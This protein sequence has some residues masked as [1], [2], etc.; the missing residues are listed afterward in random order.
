MEVIL[1]VV[2]SFF[3]GC[4]LSLAI[5]NE[6]YDFGAPFYTLIAFVPFY[7]LF[8]KK[9]K[10]YKQAFFAGFIQTITT[11]LFSSYWLAYFKDFAAITLGASAFGTG[12][13]GGFTALFL[14]LPFSSS[15]NK[16]ELFHKTLHPRF[17]DVCAF[18]IV[19]FSAI[20]TLYEWIKSSG[21]LG[22]PWGT[23]SSAMYKWPILMQISSVAGTYGITF[24]ILLINSLFAQTF[25]FIFEKNSKKNEKDSLLI[26][27]KFVA[28]LLLCSLVYGIYQYAKP[29]NPHKI[30]TTVMVQQ[31]SNPWNEETDEKS[32]LI[33]QKLTKQR[34]DELSKINKKADLVVWSEGC[35]KYPFPNSIHYY[36]KYPFENP[37]C[38]FIAKTNVPFL[39]GGSFIK[40]Q[41]DDKKI[42]NAALL[43]DKD[44]NLRGEYGKNHLVPFAES[45][46]F[47][48][49]PKIKSFMKKV[50]GISAGWSPGDQYVFF[51]IP[52]KT[53]KY[54][55]LPAVKNIDITKTLDEQ[56][57]E[58]NKPVT[59]KFSTPVCFD[60]SFTDIMRPMFLNG[61]ELFVNITDDSWSLKRSS[62]IQ[63]FIIASYRAIEYRTTLIRSCNAGY[64]VVVN[65]AGKVIADMPLFTEYSIAV[66]VPVYKR[67]MTTY[68]RFGNWLPYTIIILFT[69]FT[70]YFRLTF[71]KSDY[72]PSERKIKHKKKKKKIRPIK[73]R[74]RSRS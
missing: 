45:L 56:K 57:K 37:L 13:I 20:Y 32:I 43:F 27:F 26:T 36:Q 53:T 10:N 52:C 65:P 15:Q 30:V 3:S 44:G 1:Q 21:F 18:K 11:H 16:N 2:Y 28:A 42:F 73:A 41:N 19:Y 39:F 54:Y 72:I 47:I 60:D 8:A 14:Y 17:Y 33:S 58:E 34:T 63:H 4:L 64:S 25:I 68:A 49:Y 50:I 24:L 46:P 74:Y 69:V 6:I 66:D 61:A 71:E 67:Q 51:E 5:P 7:I 59:V 70:F 55:R 29:R 12:M 62:E 35:L 40:E 22:Y 23:V 38:P 31:N 9:I 48:E